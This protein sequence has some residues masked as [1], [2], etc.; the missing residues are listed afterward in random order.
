MI[1]THCHLTHPRF[2]PDR[3]RVVERAREQGLEACISI[4]TGIEDARAVRA[5]ARRYPGF[6]HATA[7]L[8]PFTCHALGDRFDGGFEELGRLF[9]EERFVALG[10]VG[11]DYHHDLDPRP[12]QVLRLERQLDLARALDLPVVIHVRE[13]HEDLLRI[14]ASR[15]DVDRGVIHSFTGGPGEAERYLERGFYLAFNGVITFPRAGEVRSAARLAPAARLLLE[16]DSP[17]LAPAS[18]RG[19]RCEPAWIAHTLRLLATERGEDPET[20]G[21]VTSDNARRLF[22]LPPPVGSSGAA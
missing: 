7:G 4:G 16:T 21:R 5:L 19:E 3:E 8:D 20:L 17:Y 1:D 18:R 12:V 13:A 14:L 2:D 6:V 22:G 10:E 9:A 15:G 11:L